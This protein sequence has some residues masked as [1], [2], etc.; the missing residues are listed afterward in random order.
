[1]ERERLLPLREEATRTTIGMLRHS[2]PAE[3]PDLVPYLNLAYL[4]GVRHQRGDDGLMA[5]ALSLSNW[6]TAAIKDVA[7]QTGRTVQEV[8][9]QYETELM[10]ARM[11][12][13]AEAAADSAAEPGAGAAEAD[14]GKPDGGKPDGVEE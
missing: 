10:E 1:M 3:P 4:L 13:E 11:A 6:A 12:Q 2:A 8:L 7:A 5:F 9:D 14:A